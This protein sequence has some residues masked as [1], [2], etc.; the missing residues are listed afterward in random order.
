MAVMGLF[1]IDGTIVKEGTEF[2]NISLDSF[3]YG[4]KKV[5]GVP[6]T[7]YEIDYNGKTDRRIVRE[8]LQNRGF[9]TDEISRHLEEMFQEVTKYV[10]TKYTTIN[11]E[12]CMIDGAK[13]CLDELRDRGDC[14]LGVVTGNT[15]GI[16]KLK[17]KKLGLC[18]YFNVGAFG[19][20]TEKRWKLVEQCINQVSKNFAI[21]LYRDAI[22]VVGDTPFDI[23]CAQESGT[24]PVAVSTGK[25]S[26]DQLLKYNPAHA[27][28]NLLELPAIIKRRP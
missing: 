17:L 28:D 23:E 22:Y 13:E 26:R 5:Y 18:D 9:E 14:I 6:A 2:R 27:V 24:I 3:T 11:S 16:A 21:D 25:Y 1:D 19:D 12:G 10:R 7:I 20:S 8:V 15:G 4:F